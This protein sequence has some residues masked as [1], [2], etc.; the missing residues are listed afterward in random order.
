VRSC[1]AGDPARRAY[2]IQEP[3]LSSSLSRNTPPRV[4]SRAFEG[5]SVS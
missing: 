3:G 2:G 1:G 5:R 4:Q